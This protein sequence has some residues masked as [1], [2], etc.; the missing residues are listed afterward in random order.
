MATATMT[1]ARVKVQR[2]FGLALRVTLVIALLAVAALPLVY[3]GDVWAQ[4]ISRAAIYAIIG[5]SIN[6]LTGHAGQISLGHQAFVGI[7]AFAAAFTA[8]RLGAPLGFGLAAG[9]VAGMATAAV[10]GMVALRVTGLYLAL[11]TL[12]FGLTAETTIFNWREFTGGGAGAFAPRPDI[13]SGDRAFALL[14]LGVL[15]LVLY[16]DW[17]LVSTKAGRALAAVRND[18]RIAATLGIDTT[19]Y[20]LAA[21]SLSGLA[22][23]LAGGLFAH[24]NQVVQAMD[25]EF[26]VALVWVLMTVVGG[27]RSRLGVVLASA[28]FA[29]LPLTLPNFLS[30]LPWQPPFLNEAVY[31]VLPPFIV[32]VMLLLVLRFFPG[33]LGQLLRPATR[34]LTK[35]GRR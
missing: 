10:V 15:A 26:Q 1:F 4:R 13:L 16:A 9:A 25:F 11:V 31:H 17:R 14:C 8:S 33:G 6:T 18:E 7:G 3:G 32:V 23:G 21:F 22:A 2:R 29:L 19:G 30:G 12:A 28:F 27:L 35:G 20:K 34:W 5:L 24:W